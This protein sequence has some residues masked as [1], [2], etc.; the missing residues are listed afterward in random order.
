M[1]QAVL[2]GFR[3]AGYVLG[4]ALHVLCA[5]GL[6]PCRGRDA[7]G[8][9]GCNLDTRMR[10]L[11]RRCSNLGSESRLTGTT[12]THSVSLDPERIYT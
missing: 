10:V 1:I 12:V 7:V 5:S 3:K 4:N 6:K 8:L 11:R 2:E 9:A